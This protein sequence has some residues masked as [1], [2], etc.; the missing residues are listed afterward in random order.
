MSYTQDIA[1]SGN[2]VQTTIASDVTG[3]VST[4]VSIAS[5]TGWPSPSGGQK[6]YATIKYDTSAEVK[7]SFTGRSG[8]DL[9][10]V[11]WDVDGTT[12]S[13]TY[14]AGS[15]IR[16]GWTALEA[17][18]ANDAVQNTIGK[19]TTAGDVLVGT[20]ANTMKRLGM[21]AAYTGLAVNSGATD[22]SYQATLASL[23]TA[24]ADLPYASAANTP[25]RLAKGTG[26]Q[27]LRMNAGATAPEWATLSAGTTHIMVYK[28]ADESVTSSTTVQADD[29]L[30]FA[31]G[32]NETWFAT[33]YLNTLTTSNTPDLKFDF[34][35]PASS[36]L[37]YSE[38]AMNEGMTSSVAGNT[39]WYTLSSGTVVAAGLNA[40]GASTPLLVWVSCKT[41]GTAG[42]VTFRWA[43]N[44][45]DGTAMKIAAG[46]VLIAHKIA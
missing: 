44:T 5:A 15:T 43:Q 12:S 33:L 2:A 4:T 35:S 19:I 38:I 17:D 29:E 41:A 9:T 40:G 27:Y 21:G 8:T 26:L 34:T 22:L 1:H 30:L 42:T 13:G 6:S 23:L 24:Q 3:G 10:G 39:N 32:A 11:A 7:I 25:A 36:T 45:S 20:A 14:A 46:S 16:H 28:S 18:E 37:I 31:V